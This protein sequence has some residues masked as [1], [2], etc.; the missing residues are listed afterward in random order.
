M[1]VGVVVEPFSE[2]SAP[3]RC[4]CLAEPHLD[5]HQSPESAD[6]AQSSRCSAALHHMQS[7]GYGQKHPSHQIMKKS[8]E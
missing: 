2:S 3:E 8:V 6:M 4:C 7:P 1:F 5:A